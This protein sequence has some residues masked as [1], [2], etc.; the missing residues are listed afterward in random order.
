DV[1]CTLEGTLPK[2]KN[3]M[4]F[5]N[6]TGIRVNYSIMSSE[7]PAFSYRQYN[8]YIVKLCCDDDEDK[9]TG[10]LIVNIKKPNKTKTYEPPDWFMMSIAISCGPIFLMAFMACFVLIGTMFIPGEVKKR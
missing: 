2:T 9:S 4:V 7:S 6:D 10:V 8:S 5:G 3:F 1:C